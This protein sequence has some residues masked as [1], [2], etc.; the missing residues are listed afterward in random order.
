MFNT[1]FFVNTAVAGFGEALAN[2]QAT[3]N[4]RPNKSD[5]K[6]LIIWYLRL[7]INFYIHKTAAIT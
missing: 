3:N 2:E 6:V 1:S 7:L 4:V 5:F